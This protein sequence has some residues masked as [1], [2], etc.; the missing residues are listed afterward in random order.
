MH[1][2][3]LVIVIS[4][5]ITVS[6]QLITLSY[7]THLAHRYSST[8]N[9]HSADMDQRCTHSIQCNYF[10]IAKR[11]ICAVSTNQPAPVPADST[12]SFIETRIFID[13][14]CASSANKYI[15]RFFVLKRVF[16]EAPF[17]S[18][19]RAESTSSRESLP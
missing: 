17:P 10:H 8:S 14:Q 2:I 9:P 16:M 1:I 18:N 7:P 19:S 3:I 15:C 4:D 12:F 6:H 13:F 5:I 11:P